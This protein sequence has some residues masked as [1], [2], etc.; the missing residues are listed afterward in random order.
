[1]PISF[2]KCVNAAWTRAI[3]PGVFVASAILASLAPANAEFRQP[4]NSR[5]AVE[6]GERFVPAPRFSGFYDPDTGASFVMIEMPGAAYRELKSMPQHKDSLAERGLTDA[7]EATLDGRE[8]EY[9]YFTAK[10]TEAGTAFAKFVLIFREKNLTGFITANV[11]QD[12]LDEGLMSKEDIEAVLKT[13][14]IADE[15]GPENRLF[16]LGY[17]GPL[18]LSASLAGTAEL[19]NLSGAGPEAG[20][21][22]LS[23]EPSLMVAPSLGQDEVV[24]VEQAAKNRFA[25]LSGIDDRKVLGEEAVTIGGLPGYSIAAEASTGAGSDGRIVLIFVMLRGKSG[26]YFILFG[27]TPAADQEKYLPELR[28]VIFSFTPL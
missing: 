23:R 6:L 9:V 17:L 4:P 11:P 16:E 3:V 22:Q 10:Q 19:Y 15:P 20:V 12:A 28:K 18:K 27:T 26:G 25:S 1:M 21:N 2:R 8:G 14:K 24:N 7:L 13:A 5:I